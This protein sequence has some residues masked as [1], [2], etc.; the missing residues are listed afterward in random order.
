MLGGCSSSVNGSDDGGGDDI[1]N[2]CTSIRE[3][4]RINERR[5][6]KCSENRKVPGQADGALTSVSGDASHFHSQC[7]AQ[8]SLQGLLSSPPSSHI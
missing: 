3:E 8:L 6:C 5:K 4:V 7:S 2:V 1:N